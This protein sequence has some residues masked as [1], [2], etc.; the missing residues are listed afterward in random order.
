M[1]NE[2]KLNHVENKKKI[3]KLCNV[4][5]MTITNTVNKYLEHRINVTCLKIFFF[6][7]QVCGNQRLYPKQGPTKM[8]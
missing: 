3:H 5:S 6:T 1:Q 7:K 4:Y 2:S 8:F